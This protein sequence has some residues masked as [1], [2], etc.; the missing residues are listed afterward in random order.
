MLFTRHQTDPDGPAIRV[1]LAHSADRVAVDLLLRE[2]AATG[3]VTDARR[4]LRHDP[5]AEVVLC[6]TAWNGEHEQVVGVASAPL[7]A[8]AHP[9]VL[10]SDEDGAPGTAEALRV[11]TAARV[12]LAA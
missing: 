8:G 7:R 6:A 10:V 3:V 9:V 5:R 2:Q 11:A 12:A 1:R 4:L